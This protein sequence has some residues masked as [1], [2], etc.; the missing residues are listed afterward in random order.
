ME[1]KTFKDYLLGTI[2][3][4][5]LIVVSL[6]GTYAVYYKMYGRLFGGED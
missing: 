5:I 6:V 3:G 2:Q 4:I 1:K